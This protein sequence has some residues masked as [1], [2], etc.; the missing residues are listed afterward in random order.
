MS[1]LD[2]IALLAEANPFPVADLEPLA[3]PPLGRRPERRRVVLAVALVAAAIAASV[4]GVLALDG[5][6]SHTRTGA[7]QRPPGSN[8]PTSSNGPTGPPGPPPPTIARP[9]YSGEKVTLAEAAAAIDQ[10]VVLPDTPLVGPGNVGAVWAWSVGDPRGVVVVTYPAQ[11]VM[12]YYEAPAPY[13]AA[14]TPAKAYAA[15]SREI[16]GSKVI[17]LRGTPAIWIPGNNEP[18]PFNAVD[19]QIN[20]LGVNVMGKHG[21]AALEAIARSIID[22]SPSKSKPA[23]LGLLPVLDRKRVSLRKAS[24]RL[25]V[26][27]PL[28]GLRLLKRSTAGEGWQSGTCPPAAWRACMILIP[29]PAESVSLVYQRPRPS[30]PRTRRQY[31]IEAE[32]MNKVRHQAEVIDLDG[33][34]A[35]A[36]NENIHGQHNPGSISFVVGGTRVVVA[37]KRDTAV[38]RAIAQSIVDR[39]K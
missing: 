3:P 18:H 39:S 24:R 37:G 7:I 38:L 14:H 28:P 21:E 29:F 25:G 5:T 35:L 1:D 32:H 12:V 20:G 16:S 15:L 22:R 10:R 36:I 4:V 11:S 26:A 17:E 31:E 6:S 19:F 2:V 13:S 30:W 23:G 34:P 8:G 27:I 9:L 33:V